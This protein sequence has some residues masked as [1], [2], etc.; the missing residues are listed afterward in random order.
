MH[1][2]LVL[3]TTLLAALVSAQGTLELPTC[4]ISCISDSL[5]ADCGGAPACICGRASFIEGISCCIFTSCD[6][7]D[8]E[9]ALNYAHGICD[10]T[11]EGGLLPA[12]AGCADNSTTNGTDTTSTTSS[13]TESSSTESS[14]TTTASGT[15]SAAST[16]SGSETTTTSA[17]ESGSASPAA[18]ATDAAAVVGVHVGM[19][20]AAALA[21]GVAALL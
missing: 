8:S 12:Q 10:P 17:S 13:A 16:T 7:A 18:S 6:E 20:A 11:G 14:A 1:L 4:A 3:S 15:E 19:G 9:K 5:P 2:S 21:V